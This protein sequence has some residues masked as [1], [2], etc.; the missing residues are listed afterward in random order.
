MLQETLENWKNH[1]R[2]KLSEIREGNE[3]WLWAQQNR[4]GHCIVLVHGL[5]DSPHFVRSI[6]TRFYEMGFSVLAP[7]LP[8]HGL[9]KPRLMKE[10]SLEEWREEI[11]IAVSMAENLGKNVSIGGLSLGGALALERALKKPE[12]ISGGLF[13]FSAA[14]DLV[15]VKG[16]LAE[17]ALRQD[18]IL[19]PLAKRQDRKGKSLIGPNP[20]RYGRMDFDAAGQL[21]E[22]I[23]D[24]DKRYDNKA[25]YSDIFQPVFIAHSEADPTADIRDLEKLKSNHPGDSDSVEFFRIPKHLKVR[26][27]SVVLE[28]DIL[29]PNGKIVEARNPMFVEMI[30]E[31][32]SFV[33][34]QVV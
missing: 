18:A 26:H 24:I 15:G 30:T 22:L 14:M 32:K 34:N 1:Y 19:D 29:G 13:L 17:K 8:A 9:K 27:A 2:E 7:L 16:D 4:R 6:G 10:A 28:H 3:P 11:R 20:Y 12:D 21:A 25:R 23:R 33:R 31:M 5:T